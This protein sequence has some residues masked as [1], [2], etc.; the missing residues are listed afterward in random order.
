[1]HLS[2]DKHLSEFEPNNMEVVDRN[3]PKHMPRDPG[4]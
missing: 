2:I 4:E 1:M 3:R